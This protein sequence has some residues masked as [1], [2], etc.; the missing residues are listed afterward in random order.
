MK[1]NRTIKHES[2]GDT[3]VALGFFDGVHVAHQKIINTTIS[4]RRTKRLIPT[5]LTFQI[6]TSIPHKR[7]VKY[8]LS[9][10]SKLDIFER[11]GVE[12]VYIPPFSELSELSSTEFFNEI[13]LKR[14]KAK[15]IVCGYDY[16]FGKDATGNTD[17]LMDLCVQNNIEL[18]IANPTKA[19][20]MIV[21]STAIRQSLEN[22][23]LKLANDLLGYNYFI[24]GVVCH[25]N[26]LG[27]AL[28]FPTANI[29]FA[30][31]QIIPKFGVYRTIVYIGAKIYRGLTNVG[32]KPTIE[33]ERKPLAE[34]FILG[35][36]ED[37]YGQVITLSFS[38]MI[39]EEKKFES[40]EELKKQ[41]QED[42]NQL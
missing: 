22:G 15:V 16:T 31:N 18:V 6:D 33:G 4:Y 37:L 17:E 12:Q 29:E 26:H 9:D 21:S 20:N 39:R 14:L 34:T 1:I 19:N 24:K 32:V 28:G 40:I 42:L 23:N 5:V 30:D 36:D 27:R 11:H 25:G 35:L 41:M 2:E 7:N 38:S 3:A 13:L 8:I 10:Q